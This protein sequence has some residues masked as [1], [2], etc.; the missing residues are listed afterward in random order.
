MSS[1]GFFTGD[2]ID[3]PEQASQR[4]PVASKFKRL[5]EFDATRAETIFA[6]ASRGDDILFHVG[7]IA[8]GSRA[9]S[10]HIMPSLLPEGSYDK[11]IGP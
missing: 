3:R 11:S 8:R 5:A 1:I 4:F 6:S 7:M 9:R 2:M 10:S